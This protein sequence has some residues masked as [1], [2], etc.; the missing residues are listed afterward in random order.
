VMVALISV[1]AVSKN[2]E[3]AP[4]GKGKGPA[5]GAKQVIS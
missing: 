5:Y 1:T 3:A 2:S 4:K